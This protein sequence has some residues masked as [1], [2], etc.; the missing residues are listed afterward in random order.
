[1]NMYICCLNVFH[2]FML[3]F[4][5]EEGNLGEACKIKAGRDDIII[6]KTQFSGL[7]YPQSF[8]YKSAM[9]KGMHVTFKALA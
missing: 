7:P 4:F 6:C 5:R 8:H 1:M 2:F 3:S 9:I